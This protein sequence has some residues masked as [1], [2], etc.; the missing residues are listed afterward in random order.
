MA[1]KITKACD[2]IKVERMILCIYGQPGV[3]KTSL[4]FT[5]SRPLLF[6]FDSGSH[7][8]ANRKDAVRPES[9]EDVYGVTVADLDNYDTVI[10]DT[11]GRA[12]DML[13]AD[14]IRRNPKMGYGG[15]LSLQGYGQLKAEFTAWLKMICSFGKDVVLIAHMDEQRKGDEIIERLDVQG[16]SKGEIYKCSDAMARYRVVGNAREL[17]FSPSDTGFGKNPGQLAPLAVTK[18]DSD[19][20]ANVI[21]SIKDRLNEQTE[22]ARAAQVEIDAWR[23]RFAALETVEQF[24]AMVTE[25][26]DVA[27]KIK[28]LL[29]HAA[30]AKGFS[31]DREAKVFIAPEAEEVAA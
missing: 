11:A 1:L 21:Q 15:S 8:A 19:F 31:F 26:K 29:L 10:L 22:E 25:A 28:G 17:N 7:R 3:G 14:I 5:A 27:P 4:G 18:N 23:E 13:T 16:G 24:N 12:L 2:P 6:D 30:E 9:W 20:L